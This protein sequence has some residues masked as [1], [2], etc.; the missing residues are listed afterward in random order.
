MI[1]SLSFLKMDQVKIVQNDVIFEITDDLRLVRVESDM[2][3]D[4]PEQTRTPRTRVGHNPSTRQ[5][6]RRS[7]LDYKFEGGIGSGF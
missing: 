2:T 6:I 3:T 7:I 5:I 4:L 1:H